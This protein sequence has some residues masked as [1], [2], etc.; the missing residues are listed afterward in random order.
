M[1][2]QKAERKRILVL[3]KGLGIGGAE[4]LVAEAARMWDRERFD[5]RVA[6][7]L[8]WKD[9]L[10]APLMEAGVEVTPL[11]WRGAPGSRA[12]LRLR[13]LVAGWRPDIIHSH[14]PSAGLLARIVAPRGC[15]VYT[16][17]NIV[18]SY[19][20]PTRLLNQLTYGVNRCVIAVSE[21]VAKSL[22]RYPG[23]EPRIIPN[24]VSVTVTDQQASQ[25]R[26]ELGLRPEDRLVV[27]VGNIR[28]HKGHVNLVAAAAILLQRLPDVTIVSIGGEKN[29]GDLERVRLLAEENGVAHR[30]S[31]LGRRE[32]ARALMAAADLVVN[33]ADVEGLPVAILEALA[34]ARPVVATAVGG[35]PA[36]IHHEETGLL[37]PPADPVRLATALEMGLS[38]PLAAEWGRQGARL[39]QRDYGLE[40]MVRSY[41]ALYREVLDG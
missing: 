10:V 21:A 32:D 24:G 25:A 35:V 20:Q 9:Q 18:T 34:L 26:A 12:A 19:R 38:S 36:V 1:S 37:V 39:V 7:M 40:P 31:F 27:H 3:I 5:Y 11:D 30:L 23:P 14:L 6:Y 8:P 4:T 2:P 15:H 22:S 29:P 41:E 28:P 16:E 13:R 17:H 33:P